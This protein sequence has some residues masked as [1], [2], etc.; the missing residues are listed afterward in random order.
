MKILIVDDEEDIT[1]ILQRGLEKHG[2]EVTT[3]SDPT[4]AL[5]NFEAA[6]YDLILLDIRMPKMDG[7]ELY[8]ELKKIDSKV[9]V[10]FMTA[11]DVYYDALKELFPNTYSS[12]CFVKKPFGIQDF[13]NRIS[14]EMANS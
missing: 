8:E 7:F 12:I 10:C 4:I 9:K 3:F 5:S 14:K 1:A 11:F 6:V 13:I 2:F